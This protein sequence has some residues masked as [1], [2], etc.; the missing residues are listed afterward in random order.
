LLKARKVSWFLS[1]PHFC[2][3]KKVIMA[4]ESEYKLEDVAATPVAS[5]KIDETFRS[6][7]IG[8]W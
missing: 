7:S 8:E 2:T 6:S 4:F 5:D 3:H 1:F